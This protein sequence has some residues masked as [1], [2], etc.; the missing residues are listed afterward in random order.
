MAVT[1]YGPCLRAMKMSSTGK[2]LPPHWMTEPMPSPCSA[3]DALAAP[4]VWKGR[5][6]PP[7]GL[8]YTREISIGSDS[9]GNLLPCHYMKNYTGHSITWSVQSVSQYNLSD[10]NDPKAI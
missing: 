1:R 5:P 8:Q 6:D 10:A 2:V 4:C 7:T 3:K 9:P